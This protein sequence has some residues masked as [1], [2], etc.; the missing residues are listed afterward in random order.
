[1]NREQA[2]D[3]FW[4]GFGLTAYEESTVPDDAKLPYITYNV[5]ID[6]LNHPVSVTASI[7][8]RS[9]SWAVVSHKLNVI[10]N[11]I[12]I[13]GVNIPHDTGVIWLKKGSPFAQRVSDEDRT[14]R[15]IYMNIELEYI[16]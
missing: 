5:G 12:G 14:I 3:A 16:N 1:M 4:N 6:D 11:A 8:D 7:W 2:L 9:T 13:G 15:R 10:S